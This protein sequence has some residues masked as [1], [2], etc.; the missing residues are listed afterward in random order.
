MDFTCIAL[1]DTEYNNFV[2]YIVW[3]KFLYVFST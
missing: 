2:H 1:C 3:E